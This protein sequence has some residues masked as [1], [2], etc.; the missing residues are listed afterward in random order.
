MYF[1]TVQSD[2]C[3]QDMTHSI[4]LDNGMPTLYNMQF[5][6]QEVTNVI[7]K[8]D[9]NKALGSDDIP[10][11]VLKE[12]ALELAPSFADLFNYSMYIGAVP[13]QWK[14]AHVT[15]VFK[16]GDKNSVT[17]YRPISLFCY[18]KS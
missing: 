8:L 5:S 9:A 11:Q 17:N 16:K 1:K 3:L 13:D 18:P 4:Q 14:I 2:T 15:P 10:P 12:R 6:S 7:S